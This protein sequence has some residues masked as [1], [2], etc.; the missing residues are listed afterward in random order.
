M[1]QMC[2]MEESLPD[3]NTNRGIREPT[4]GTAGLQSLTQLSVDHLSAFSL[5]QQ[6]SRTAI[7]EFHIPQSSVAL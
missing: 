2:G 7:P 1:Y 5:R 4:E 3:F 6:Q